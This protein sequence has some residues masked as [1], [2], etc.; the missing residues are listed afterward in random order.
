MIRRPPRSTLFPYTTL[1]RSRRMVDRLGLPV[2]VVGCRTVREPEGLALSSRN[3][4]LGPEEREQATCLFLGLSEAASLARAG[5]RDAAVLVATI[6]REVG[7][8]PL[9]SLDYAGVVADST[10]E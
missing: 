4:L 2:R 3:A 9:A 6:A 8:T 5:G 10:F 1:F 7:A